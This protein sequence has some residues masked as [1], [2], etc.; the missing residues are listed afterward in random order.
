MAW[1][2]AIILTNVIISLIRTPETNL[3]EILSTIHTFSSKK[4][5]LKMS[6]VK[7]LRV[8]ISLNLLKMRLKMT[9]AERLAF[10]PSPAVSSGDNMAVVHFGR[11]LPTPNF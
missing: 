9:Y 7:W 11:M 2:L 1:R 4:M 3:S 6:S 10:C 8:C 5:H